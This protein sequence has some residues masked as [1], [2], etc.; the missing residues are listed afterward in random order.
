MEEDAE[1][2]TVVKDEVAEEEKEPVE[3]VNYDE[4]PAECM[5][6]IDELQELLEGDA[7]LQSRC[8]EQ[9]TS[10]TAFSSIT[11]LKVRELAPLTG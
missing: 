3:E 5:A 11:A 2:A 6:K 9:L 7:G 10:G 8:L 1:E 4:K